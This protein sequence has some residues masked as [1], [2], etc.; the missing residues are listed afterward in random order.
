MAI[1]VHRRIVHQRVQFLISIQSISIKII[2][3]NIEILI[4]AVLKPL[5]TIFDPIDL[6][7]FTDS[8]NWSIWAG[9]LNSKNH[10]WNTAT[11]ADRHSRAPYKSSRKHPL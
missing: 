8:L 7:T 3:N 5:K 1:F 6:D 9:R 4:T 11:L 2:A 10:L